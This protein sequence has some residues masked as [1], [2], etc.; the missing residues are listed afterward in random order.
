MYRGQ[1]C[2]SSFLSRR[3]STCKATLS[4]PYTNLHEKR[5]CI[6][7]AMIRSYLGVLYNGRGAC[8]MI[9]VIAVSCV[10]WVQSVSFV[11]ARGQGD[12]FIC[13]GQVALDRACLSVSKFLA[14]HIFAPSFWPRYRMPE[15]H[16][17]KRKNSKSFPELRPTSSR[18]LGSKF[19]GKNSF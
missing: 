6:I 11:Q 16:V 10:C 8:S 17:R 3:Y 14:L 13:Y 7:V 15:H 12:D 19:S 9:V 5:S 2:N 4:R 1:D 18:R